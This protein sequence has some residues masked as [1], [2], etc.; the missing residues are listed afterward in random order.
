MTDFSAA[1]IAQTDDGKLITAVDWVVNNGNP[2]SS[3]DPGK[4][5]WLDIVIMTKLGLL[6]RS[7]GARYSSGNPTPKAF[8]VHA[9]MVRLGK[10]AP[11]GPD[12]PEDAAARLGSPDILTTPSLVS[13][14]SNKKSA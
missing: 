12:L 5:K 2:H 6:T 11:I 1:E 8:E 4:P 9:E 10:C 14:L 3:E 13:P 7:D